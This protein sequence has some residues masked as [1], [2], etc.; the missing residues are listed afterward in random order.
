MQ[1]SRRKSY[2]EEE[3]LLHR[4]IFGHLS[5]GTTIT[6]WHPAIIQWSYRWCNVEVQFFFKRALPAPHRHRQN[7]NKYR[8]FQQ[9]LTLPK[10]YRRM[11]SLHHTF[12]SI[13]NDN[14]VTR[15]VGW[16]TAWLPATVKYYRYTG[17]VVM[18]YCISGAITC[19][20]HSS[21]PCENSSW[22]LI[23]A[24]TGRCWVKGWKW[25]PGV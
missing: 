6:K 7:R 11:H 2:H 23:M 18:K 15:V 19:T 9:L 14:L 20:M 8:H 12:E 3:R 4:T 22:D 10:F 13:I 21:M 25:H 24:V 1:Y 16:Y 5:A 17:N